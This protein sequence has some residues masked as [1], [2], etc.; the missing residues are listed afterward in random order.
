MM[1]GLASAALDQGLHRRLSIGDDA[2]SQPLSLLARDPLDHFRFRV[3][4]DEAAGGVDDGRIAEA[5]CEVE[6]LAEEDDEIGLAAEPRRR[7]RAA[8]R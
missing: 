6:R 8:H 3:D 5:Q 2:V 7:R 1:I 4:D